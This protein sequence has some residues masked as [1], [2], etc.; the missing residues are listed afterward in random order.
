MSRARQGEGRVRPGDGRVGRRRGRRRRRRALPRLGRGRDDGGVLAVRRPRPAR[1]RP[2]GDLRRAVLADLAGDRLAARRARAPLARLRPCST[3]RATSRRVAVGP[4]EANLENAKKIRDDWQAGKPDPA[5]D[6]RAPGDDPPGDA[7]GR[8]GRGRQAAQRRGV[9]P[10]SLWDAVVLGG[11]ELLMRKPGIVS[12]HAV[13]SANALHFIYGAS[14]DDTTR[15]LALLQAVGWLP[16]YRGRS[17][18]ADAIRDR[19]PRSRS[20]PSRGGDEAVG[21]LF[22]TIIDRTATQAAPRRRSATSTGAA[23]PT[24]V[25]AAARRMIFHKGTRQPR[26]QVRR[27]R[28]GGMPSSPPTRSG[29]PP[30]PPP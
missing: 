7:R 8:L 29:S 16:L 3:S 24:C 11:S 28:L 18:P 27:R 13:T 21:E 30:W 2:Q 9:A 4:Y 12:I 23:R 22:A 5:R 17:K 26:L 15:R 20:R 10:D 19:R 14:G 1:H 6:R 25:F